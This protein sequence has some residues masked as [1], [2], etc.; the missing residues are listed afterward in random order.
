M[1]RSRHDHLPRLSRS[2]TRHWHSET[3]TLTNVSR[4][5]QAQRPQAES[6]IKGSP[7]HNQ[8]SDI[9]IEKRDNDIKNPIATHADIGLPVLRAT[10][11]N[12]QI[13]GK[14]NAISYH[15]FHENIKSQKKPDKKHSTVGLH[16]CC[17]RHGIV[18]MSRTKMRK[19]NRHS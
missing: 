8:I 13:R 12:Y 9:S 16:N 18:V 7:H 3:E 1:S 10:A 15:E 14:I 4:D 6:P 5:I 17:F 11:H 19:T 2:E